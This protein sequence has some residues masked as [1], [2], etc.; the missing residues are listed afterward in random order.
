MGKFDGIL[1]ATD[2][3]GTFY[4]NGSLLEDNLKA[5]RYFEENG[6]KFTVCSGRYFEF[7]KKFSKEVPTNTY[8]VCYNGAYIIDINNNDI[9]YEGF[10][11]DYVF[12]IVDRLF[13][14]GLKYNDISIYHNETIEPVFLTIDEYRKNLLEIKK[15]NVYKIILRAKTPEDARLGVIE[16]N[17]M[18]LGDYIAVRSW[19]ISLELIK[20]EN[21]KGVALRRVADKIGAQ[22]VVSVGDYENDIEMLKASDIGYAVGNA[23]DTLKAVADRVTVSADKSAIAHIIS[24]LERE[25]AHN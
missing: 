16:A 23:I 21:S 12:D 10:C 18:D 9:L 14:A 3:D 19:E 2:W 1:L 17:K 24:D 15:K 5:I 22:L 13:A 4:Y 8:L 6:G 25:F 11:D 20:R 7:I